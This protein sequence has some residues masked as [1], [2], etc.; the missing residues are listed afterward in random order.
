M[1]ALRIITDGGTGSSGGSGP[2]PR[3]I[4]VIG[5]GI[6]GQAVV[7]RVRER[8]THVAITLLCGEDRLPYDRVSLSRILAEGEDASVLQLRPEAWYADRG[9]DVRLGSRVTALDA[10]AGTATLATGEVLTF[11]RAVLCTGSDAFVPPIP[12]TDA[13]G[14]EVF[15]GP[16]DCEAIAAAVTAAD[17]GRAVVIGGGLLGLEAAYGIATLG[18]PVT[19]VHLM[20]RLMERQLDAGAAALLA[21]A[22][23]G[24]GVDVLLETSTT[25]IDAGPDGRVAGLTFADGTA[26]RAGLVVVAVGIKPQAELAR[27]SG[28][29]VERGIVVDDRMVTSHP[30]VLSVGECAQHR[31][32]CHGIVAP[33]HEQAA[34]AADTLTGAADS[35]YLGSI[36]SAKLKVMGVGLV[37]AGEASG[38]RE[39][40]VADAGVYRKLVVDAEDRVVGTVLLGDTRGAELLLEAVRSGLEAPDPL[41]LLA[42]ASAA[43]A[44]ELPDAAQICNCNGVCKGDILKAITDGDLGSTQEVVSVTRAGAGCGSCKPLVTELL[45]HARGG[46]VEEATYLCPCK[47][48]TRADIAG[49][50]RD[51]GLQSVSEI[52]TA[53]GAGRDCGACK[54]GMAYLV[55]EINGNQHREERHARFIND[56]VH[57]NI[58]NDGTFSVVPRMRG[59]VTTPAE[60]RR[61]ADVAD[62]YDIPTVKVTG[63]QRID[64]LG[65]RKEDLP[66]VWEELDMPSGHAYAKSVR[67]VKTCV[68]T[69]HC[70]FGLGDAMGVGIEL[71]TAMEGL[72]TPAK[73]KAA[74]TGCPR[75]CAEAY[76]KD[77]GLVAV[78]GGWEIYV[79][80]AAGASVRKGDLLATVDTADEAQRVALAFLQYYRE[81][82][83]YLERTYTY[84]ER[85]GPEAVQAE[86]LDP[87]KQEEYLERYRI[88]KAACDP[89]PWKERHAPATPKQFASLDTAPAL[90]PVGPPAGAEA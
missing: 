51:G 44:A 61:I 71:E 41:A 45:A 87:E 10:D 55:S 27:A 76:V 14:V 47:K 32:V 84:M 74:V 68:G 33:I 72:Y 4:L 24:L 69:T 21:P 56:R 80:G 31:G 59:G 67:T 89:D 65:V 7:E 37:T 36:P 2:D 54:P 77:I 48:L 88:A 1:A 85:V 25:S 35:A 90:L 79:G 38:E 29:A 13:P 83:D 34:V 75:N 11:D 52:A 53:C 64:L 23:E 70:R 17:A 49:H 26:L 62:K 8:D 50:V 78:E 16:E 20:D 3:R 82:A 58:Q 22:I 30:K 9:V 40:L 86:V 39:V 46:A 18:C 43:T 73:V 6:A 12:G 66:A 42:A 81:H 15:R 57:A 60:L 63:G 28:L 5:G 19:V